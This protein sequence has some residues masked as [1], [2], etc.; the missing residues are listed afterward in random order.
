ML[1]VTLL[2]LHSERAVLRAMRA[3][4]ACAYAQG[5]TDAS[6]RRYA[7]LPEPEYTEAS[8]TALI[9]G[10]I[11][12]GLEQGNLAVLAIGGP[13]TGQFAGSL[14]LFD[15]TEE[16]AEVGFWVHPG[17]RGKGVAGAAL[18]L[19]ALLAQRSGLTRLVARTVPENLASQ[20]VLEGA[21]FAR[22]AETSGIAPSGETA[23]LLHYSRE[24]RS[25]WSAP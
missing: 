7:H 11:R 21:G 14:V 13:S 24:L 3:G 23:V 22:G 25:N 5:T 20:R 19:A 2:P 4:D 12:E 16:S 8:V 10:A 17:H 1:D 9:Q 6:V 18:S 15:V